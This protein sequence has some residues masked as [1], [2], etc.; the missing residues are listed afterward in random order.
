M[1]GMMWNDG[2]NP[3]SSHNFAKNTIYC[4]NDEI[5]V[6]PDYTQVPLPVITGREP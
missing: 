2:I 3:L 5:D 4:S 6:D 1:P